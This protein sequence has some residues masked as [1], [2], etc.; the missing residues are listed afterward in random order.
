MADIKGWWH[1]VWRKKQPTCDIADPAAL[2]A[3]FL[4]GLLRGIAPDRERLMAILYQPLADRSRW[5][6]AAVRKLAADEGKLTAA[7]GDSAWRL[8][9][10]L[11]LPSYWQ[12]ILKGPHPELKEELLEVWGL[13]AVPDV[14]PLLRTA[15]M[16]RVPTVGLV[17][18][19]D[20]ARWPGPE[21]T[22]F[23]LE[24]LLA[25]G[26]P[27]L[28]RSGRALALRRQ[29][30][31]IDIWL[32][33]LQLARD[34][35]ENVRARAWAVVTSF[36][37]LAEAEEATVGAAVDDGLMEALQDPSV[38]VRIRALEALG[39]VARPSL[40]RQAVAQLS[41]GDGRIRVEAVR[42]L[43]RLA[44]LNLLAPEDRQLAYAGVAACLHDDDYRVVGHAQ[45][46][47]PYLVEG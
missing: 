3:S 46:V 5:W 2:V 16:D 23:F 25:E 36:G 8:A 47:L 17:A 19:M 13:M 12:A 4:N 30:E 33:L 14:A 27:W 40:V 38:P 10:I 41:N 15:V 18:A 42:A 37:P 20:Y 34:E 35:R 43:G 6:L 45:Q 22:A 31:G 39:S 11:F 9:R 7:Q 1:R 29:T 32:G 21:V 28:D 24:L 26:G 44:L